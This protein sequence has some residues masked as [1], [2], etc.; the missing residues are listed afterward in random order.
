LPPK[1][2]VK[3]RVKGA[4][5]LVLSMSVLLNLAPATAQSMPE[6]N[7]PLLALMPWPAAIQVKPG[8]F[9]IHSRFGI[10]FQGYREARLQRAAERFIRVLSRETEIPLSLGEASDK[11]QF[12]IE[13][14]GASHVVQ[15]LGEDESYQLEITPDEVH[16]RAPNPLGILHGLQTF[17]QLIHGTRQEGFS[18]PAV[19]IDDHPRFPWRGLMIDTGRHFM[20]LDVIKRNLD[21][22]EAV[23]L[24]VFHWHLSEDQGFRAES[25]RFP[26][27]QGKGSDGHY[28]T[29][30]QMRSVVEYAR[31]RGIRVVPEFDMPAHTSSWFVG[32]P[33]LASGKGPYHIERNWG[34]FNPTMDPT[35]EST[36]EFLDAFIGEM[37]AIFPDAYFHIGGDECTGKEWDQNPRIQ[38]FMRAHGI[39]D[40][41]ALQAYFTARVQ[42]IVAAHGK[43]MEGWD[44]VL[45]PDTPKD[46]VIQSWRGQASLADAASRGYRGILSTGYYI[47]LNLPASEHYLADP[48]AQETANLTDQQKQNILGGEAAMWSEYVSPENIDSRIW[49]RTA[50]IA[51]RLWSPREVRDVT[52]MYARLALVSHRLELYGLEHN[53][54]YPR[55]LR[56]MTK[57][58][59]ISSLRVLGDV[60]QP[61]PRYERHHLAKYDAF[62][63]LNELVD[64]VPPE[65]DTARQFMD[66]V[67]T[68]V[69]GKATPEDWEKARR[70]LTLW[71]DNDAKLEPLLSKSPRLRELRPVSVDLHKVAVAG[72]RAL[73]YLEQRQPAPES[74]RTQTLTFLQQAAQPQAVVVDMAAP[75]VTK[76]V[77]A[78]VTQ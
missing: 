47:D 42:K 34:V 17:L 1:S 3:T 60:V 38:A 62:T 8:E 70:C 32:Y 27:L 76:L 23:K 77:D 66:L 50:A 6:Q 16:L 9:V 25:K 37:A 49:P 4:L 64:A 5:S 21:G 19:V 43:I 78:T 54:S 75:P 67:N 71:R 69:S 40:S 11:P 31:D 14:E 22:M 28:Y 73:G 72:L 2:E 12:F 13:T 36:Y 57:G 33:N 55:I 18:A 39:K 15:Q 45:Q 58:A 7:L 52:F 48:I 61:P 24:N 10:V 29:Q 20:P 74:W 35:R 53:T 68:I 44:E 51:E 63:P 59:D 46:V 65:S 26:L 30:A 41:A 56:Q